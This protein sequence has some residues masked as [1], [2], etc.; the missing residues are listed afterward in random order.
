[1]L[2]GGGYGDVR[3]ALAVRTGE[4]DTTVTISL[5]TE[6]PF[7]DQ[8][9]VMPAQQQEVGQA[10][11]AAV[12]PLEDVMAVHE[13][14]LRASWEPAA[15]V[16]ALQRPSYRRSD[17]AGLPAHAERVTCAVLADRHDAGVASESSGGLPGEGTAVVQLAATLGAVVDQ[18]HRI[19]VDDDLVAIAARA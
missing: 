14:P 17:G 18:G 10:G 5:Q 3:D 15:S 6:A 9:M 11:L 1:M 2:A 19:H 16:A 4:N 8:P 7:V 12:S 13:A